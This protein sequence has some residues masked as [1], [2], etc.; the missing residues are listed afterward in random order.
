MEPLISVIIPV[1]NVEDYL[2]YCLKSVIEQEYKNL[3]IILVDDG[4]SDSSGGICEEYAKKDSRIKVIHKKNGG[5]SSARN[6]GLD[7]MTGDYISFVDSDDYIRV[8]YISQMVRYIVEDKTDLV[9]CSTKKT[10][11]NK[12]YRFVPQKSNKHFVY[13]SPTIKIKMISKKVPMYSVSKLFKASFKEELRFPEGKLF[14]DIVST[15]NVIKKVN[16]VTFSTDE[17]Y[18]YRQRTGSIVNSNYN[19]NRM[20]QLFFS[21]SI[22]EEISDKG[23]LKNVAGTRCFFAA[24]DTYALVSKDYPEDINLII[25][26]IIKHRVEVLKY[27]KNIKLDFLAIV[28]FLNVRFVRVLGIAYK[29]FLQ[30]KYMKE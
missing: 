9:I 16:N 3:E 8:D 19:H 27:G 1:F 24:V 26:S 11:S 14:E 6:V 5:L 29:K 20:D 12:D 13:D 28:S 10:T 2:D 22:Y 25:N 15:W 17:L 21:E 7:V 18:Y 4:S 23:V 30:K